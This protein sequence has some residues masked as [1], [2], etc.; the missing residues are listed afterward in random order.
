MPAYKTREEWL[1]AAVEEIRPIFS[2]KGHQIP[3][4]CQVSCGFA[5]TGTR[6]HHIGQCWSR[7]SSTHERNQIFISPALYEPAEVLDT[8][9]HELVHAVDNCEHKHGKEFKKMA[10][11]LGMVGPMRSAGA[12]PELKAKLEV[13]AQALGSYPHGKLKVVH[14]KAISRSRPRAKCPTCGF[15]VPMLK[16]FLAYG[17]PICP[18]DKVE[19]EQVGNWESE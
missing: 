9:V 7:S 18:K 8:L 6:S 19:M 13:V 16:R 11:S 12:G 1:L 2:L 3:L 17:A 15:Q 5:S 4:D 10:L 14:H